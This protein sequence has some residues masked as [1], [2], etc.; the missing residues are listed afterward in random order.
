MP[1]G[2]NEIVINYQTAAAAVV[3]YQRAQR[4]FFISMFSIFEER[5]SRCLMML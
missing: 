3:C 4:H 5:F 1:S 2:R